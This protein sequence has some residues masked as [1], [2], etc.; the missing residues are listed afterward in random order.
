MTTLI[1]DWLDMNFKEYREKIKGGKKSR[2]LPNHCDL[3][4]TCRLINF[5]FTRHFQ[6]HDSQE[7][8]AAARA[9]WRAQVASI[10]W[11]LHNFSFF[12]IFIFIYENTKPKI[13]L[14]KTIQKKNTKIP[15]R[16]FFN[17]LD[18]K[19]NE[20][21]ILFVKRKIMQKPS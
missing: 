6:Q 17:F 3:S 16:S 7:I 14:K 1:F 11:R 15:F 5:S 2:L 10:C 9:A 8:L 12:F 19:D 18:L 20:I 13:K 21:I 4:N